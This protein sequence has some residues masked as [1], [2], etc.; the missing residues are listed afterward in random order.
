MSEET[1]ELNLIYEKQGKKQNIRFYETDDKKLVFVLDTFIQFIEGEDEEIYHKA[2]TKI[3]FQ[4][5]PNAKNY[6]IIGG[7]DGL[8]AREIFEFNPYVYVTL[9]DY[10]EEVIDLF[11]RVPKLIQLNK[12]SLYNCKIYTEDALKWIPENQDKKFDVIILDLPDANSPELQ[13]LYKKEFISQV[14]NLLNI[15]GIISIQTHLTIAKQIQEILKDLLGN[16]KI[17]DYETPLF[18]EGKICSAKKVK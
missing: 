15:N 5:N 9:V 4:D 18:G 6:L 2:L 17:T 16:V 10:D 1:W 14:I 11:M 13:K 8:V 7:G 12:Y 3:A